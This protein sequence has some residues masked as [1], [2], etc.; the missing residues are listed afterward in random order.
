VFVWAREGV[1]TARSNAADNN[2][3]EILGL[4]SAHSAVETAI[5]PKWKA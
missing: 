2:K 1:A 3:S 4:I 5:T